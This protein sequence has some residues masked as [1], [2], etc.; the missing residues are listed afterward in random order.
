MEELLAVVGIAFPAG[1]PCTVE[2]LPQ[3][4]AGISGASHISGLEAHVEVI[5]APQIRKEAVRLGWRAMRRNEVSRDSIKGEG[6]SW[7]EA[8]LGWSGKVKIE[9]KEHTI[10]QCFLS[11]EG[12]LQHSWFVADPN[13]VYNPR[14]VIHDVFDSGLSKLKGLPYES[15]KPNGES[16]KFEEG[17]AHLMHF[18]GFRTIHFD[19]P[20]DEAPDIIAFATNGDVLVIECTTG[21]L[22][23]QNKLMKLVSRTQKVRATLTATS[24]SGRVTP[25]LVT[26]LPRAAIADEEPE[27]LRLGVSVVTREDIEQLVSRVTYASDCHLDLAER[28]FQSAQKPSEPSDDQLKLF[29]KPA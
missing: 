2:V 12:L 13:V 4:V 26:S 16:R 23:S 7:E 6:L 22:N 9:I 18:A 1:A 14:M 19:Q 28:A 11:Y 3:I 24:H 17:I 29:N 20:I 21:V 10:L 8:P 27:A 15:G 5:C 25:V